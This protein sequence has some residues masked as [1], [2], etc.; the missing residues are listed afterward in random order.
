MVGA[1]LLLPLASYLSTGYRGRDPNVIDRFV[2]ALSAPVQG[3]LTWVVATVT[4]AVGGYVALRGAH[5]GHSEC[6]G[7]LAA[8]IAEVNALREAQ[9]ENERL[10]RAL[11]YAEG[12]GETELLARVVGINPT[13]QF[14]SLRIDRGEKDGVRSGAPVLTAVP[15]RDGRPQGAVVG[16]V[17]RS[18]A[19]SA[20]VMLLSDPASRI[21]VVTQRARVRGTAMGAGSGRRL[22]LNHVS[23]EDD[24]QDADVLVTAGTDGI[25]PRGLVVGTLRDVT[26]PAVGMFLSAVIVPAVDLQRLEEVLIIPAVLTGAAAAPSPSLTPPGAKP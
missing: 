11:A 14:Q 7:Q 12:T 13:V 6:R 16:Q 9:A 2:L 19:H 15:G 5:E 4:G 20:D 25:F 17:V 24:V 10:K 3:G 8:S 26:R 18:V 22:V 1:L 21:G 23:H